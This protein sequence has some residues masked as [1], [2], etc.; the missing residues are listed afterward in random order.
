MGRKPDPVISEYFNRGAKVA[1]TSNR[2]HWTCKQC[3]EHFPKGRV[4][5]LHNHVTKTCAALSVQEKTRLVL[6]IH[7]IGLTANVTATAAAKNKGK[8]QKANGAA[9]ASSQPLSSDRQQVF[10]SID[11]LNGLN[12]L[13]EASRQVVETQNTYSV[14]SY[15]GSQTDVSSMVIDPALVNESRTGSLLNSVQNDGTLAEH[16]KTLKSSY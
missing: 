1:D 16:G 3:G 7:E 12:V 6:Q 9:P 15:T 4:E 13:A 2:Y 14:P 11:S 8:G 5:G 10:D